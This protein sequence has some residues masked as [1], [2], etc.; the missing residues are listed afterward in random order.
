MPKKGYY[1][2]LLG[3]RFGRL[4]AIKYKGQQKRRRTMW[5]CKCECG[6][7]VIVDAS[8][9]KSSHTTSCGCKVK[10]TAATWN[11]KNGLSA[12]RLGRTYRNMINRCYRE[13]F[14]EYYLYGGR[15][16]QVCDEWRNK[17]NGFVNF[18]EWALANGYNE[19]LSIDRANNNGNYEPSN[20]RWVD[21]YVQANNKRNNHKIII[22]GEIDT[23]GNWS[24]RLNISY[25]NLLHYSKGGK[26]CKY[27]ELKIEAI[28]NDE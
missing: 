9:L 3:K 19:E 25:W 1:E 16:I 18:C 11:Y 23:V 14:P 22:N 26:N 2:D 12:S 8:H 4:V 27:P 7:T 21:K 20:C 6:K 10:E 17:E 13:N 15:G 24:R 28:K 5:E